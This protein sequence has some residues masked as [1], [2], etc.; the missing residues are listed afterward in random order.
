MEHRNRHD[1]IWGKAAQEDDINSLWGR[2][3]ELGID[4]YTDIAF[5]LQVIQENPADTQ[6]REVIHE[7]IAGF[8]FQETVSPNPF[9][10]TAPLPSDDLSGE[11]IVGRTENGA[12]YGINLDDLCRNLVLIGA[13][14][15][16][17][18]V[19]LAQLAAMFLLS[20]RLN[21]A[22]DHGG[23]EEFPGV[24]GGVR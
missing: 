16:G 18:S 23:E 21:A 19:I 22:R 1:S 7:A 12:I 15:S 4:R 17:K 14:G 5:A 8:E 24:N 3:H 20:R 6:M 10:S 11:L 2:C 13:S 9:R